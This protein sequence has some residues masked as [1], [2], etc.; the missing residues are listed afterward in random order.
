MGATDDGT[1]LPCAPVESRLFAA[2][3]CPM[4]LSEKSLFNVTRRPAAG[5]LNTVTVR[6]TLF[7]SVFFTFSLSEALRTKLPLT[8]QKKTFVTPVRNQSGK[9]KVRKVKWEDL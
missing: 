2:G 8:M 7:T 5:L 4:L 3:P 6:S 1:N 9:G